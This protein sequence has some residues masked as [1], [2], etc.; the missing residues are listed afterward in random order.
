MCFSQIRIGLAYGKHIWNG[1]DQSASVRRWDSRKR[2]REVSHG[3]AWDAPEILMGG[4]PS[5]AS[6]VY[7]LGITLWELLTGADP[8]EDQDVADPLRLPLDVVSRIVNEGLRPSILQTVPTLL[9]EFM[10][11]CWNEVS[12]LPTLRQ[13]CMHIWHRNGA[14]AALSTKIHLDAT[15]TLQAPI[16]WGYGRAP[17][18]ANSEIFALQAGFI[19][20]V[21]TI[22]S[23]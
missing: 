22:K 9:A 17:R 14:P 12:T 15:G 16:C 10:Q 5:K 21:W 13:T 20:L 8:Y 7:A 3:S 6:D 11:L 18:F 4:A 1:C 2:Q 23:T 19:F